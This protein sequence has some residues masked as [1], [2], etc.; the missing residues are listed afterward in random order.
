MI[1]A[2]W[3]AVP[4]ALMVAWLVACRLM[5]K[6]ER[7]A[8]YAAAPVRKRR[9]TLADEALEEEAATAEDGSEG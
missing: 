1:A 4:A 7:A 2:P 5:V 8:R 3:V 9:R 6:R